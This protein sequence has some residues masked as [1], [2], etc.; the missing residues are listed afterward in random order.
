MSHTTATDF[1]HI[2]LPSQVKTVL[3]DLDNTCYQYDPCHQ[4]AMQDFRQ[5]LES[6]VG[7]ITD[8]DTLYKAAQQQVKSR[9]PTHAAS[10]SRVLYA[11][12]LCELLGRT[13]AHIH[14]AHLEKVYWDTFLSTMQKTAGLDAF[15]AH[16]PKNDTTI[17]IFFFVCLFC[18]FAWR[19]VG[20][21]RIGS[22]CCLNQ[23]ELSLLVKAV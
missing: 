1:T 22:K 12:A 9:I 16:C 8:F 10:H 5:A 11:Q 23:E 3:L 4:A 2:K 15:L 18:F 20:T 6:I 13:D 14:A 21:G 17:F 19:F 7:P